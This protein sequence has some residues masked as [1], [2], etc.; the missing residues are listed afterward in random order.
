MKSPDK[1]RYFFLVL[2]GILTLGV[3]VAQAQDAA[4]RIKARLPQV[5]ALKQGG[6]VGEGNTG[7]LVVRG[8]L[9]PDQ[10]KLVEAENADRKELYALVAR[11][12]GYDVAE[13]GRQRAAQIAKNAVKGVWLQDANGKWYQKS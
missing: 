2:F 3:G 11:R 9:S 8:S 4:D 1:F 5:D 10:S 13:V 6:Q 12:A 7:F